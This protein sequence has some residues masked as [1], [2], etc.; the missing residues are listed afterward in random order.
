MNLLLQSPLL[1]MRSAQEPSVLRF[2][3]FSAVLARVT[4]CSAALRIL[5][6]TCAL[7]NHLAALS[8]FR[9]VVELVV[10]PVTKTF[11]DLRLT[12]DTTGD[13]RPLAWWIPASLIM[14]GAQ[15]FCHLWFAAN[16]ALDFVLR[17]FCRMVQF[18]MSGPRVQFQVFYSVIRAIS[19]FVV[20]HFGLKKWSIQVFRHY[21]SML[22]D[23]SIGLCIRMAR[24]VNTHIP[25]T[26]A[27]SRPVY[28]CKYTIV[29]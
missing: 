4:A 3:A 18:A 17:S 15:G 12:A 24:L 27:H 19:I 22:V 7:C 8:A 11:S 6:G 25:V 29:K 5:P 13:N 21:E 26:S 14:K 2:P 20:N 28:H 9:D 10:M 16:L 23:G 1:V